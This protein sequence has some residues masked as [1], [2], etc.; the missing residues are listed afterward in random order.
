MM[1]VIRSFKKEILLKSWKSFS[2]RTSEVRT[3]I[4]TN[5]EKTTVEGRQKWANWPASSEEIWREHYPL[6]FFRP[7]AS[8]GTMSKNTF[9]P[10]PIS[11]W[12]YCIQSLSLCHCNLNFSMSVNARKP[13]SQAQSE[14][15]ISRAWAA[16]AVS[17]KV[18]LLSERSSDIKLC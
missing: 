17:C 3:M 16:S 11:K 2:L 18:T 8:S 15:R 13:T 14:V 7:N 4:W 6:K 9:V 10:L 1:N 5:R 12:V